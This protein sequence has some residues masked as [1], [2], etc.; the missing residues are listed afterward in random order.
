[1]DHTGYMQRA[2]DE[3]R[4]AGEMGEVPVG[5]IIVCRG[6]VIATAGNRRQTSLD[7]TAHAELLAIRQANTHQGAWHLEDADLYVTQEPCPMCAGAIVN[8]R[9]KRVIFGCRNPKAGAV[10]TLYQ[11]LEDPRLNHRVEVIADV[12]AEECGA[13]LTDF[14]RTL[15]E[16]K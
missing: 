10:R 2:L 7:A 8:A 13:V 14:F 15:R 4:I 12:L 3:A 9:V 1:M 11:L 5:A 16:Q 6:E